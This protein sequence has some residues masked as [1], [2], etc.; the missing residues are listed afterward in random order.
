MFKWEARKGWKDL[1]TGF[2]DAFSPADPVE[3]WILARPFMDS[4]NVRRLR[5]AAH[6]QRMHTLHVQRTRIA[7]SC[8]H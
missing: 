5:S 6:A 8:A 7:R 1:V 4:G 2:C 3:L